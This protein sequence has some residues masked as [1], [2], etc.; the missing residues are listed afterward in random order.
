MQTADAGLKG[1]SGEISLR[2]GQAIKGSSDSF[3]FEAGST[4]FSRGGEC[5]RFTAF[6]VKK[7][8]SIAAIM[9]VLSC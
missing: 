7:Y 8:N 6:K 9:C 4:K 3:L 5:L 2:T 1:D